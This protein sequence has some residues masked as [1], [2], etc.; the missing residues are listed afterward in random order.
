MTISI[1]L[2]FE[3][4][5]RDS[6]EPD[7]I[8]VLPLDDVYFV[9]LNPQSNFI[10][11]GEYFLVLFFLVVEDHELQLQ[12]NAIRLALLFHPLQCYKQH[13]FSDLHILRVVVGYIDAESTNTCG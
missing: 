6:V 5:L 1:I 10:V 4:G 3:A 12:E 8:E 13:L 11:Q 7:E 2:K 9:C